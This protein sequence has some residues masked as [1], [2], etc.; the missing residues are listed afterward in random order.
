MK[1]QLKC[2]V[3]CETKVNEAKLKS[4]ISRRESPDSGEIPSAV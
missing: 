4:K 1:S 3:I 2:G